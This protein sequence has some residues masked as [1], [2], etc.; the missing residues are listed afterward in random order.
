M[1]GSS[2]DLAVLDH[3]SESLE[4]SRAR[5]AKANGRARRGAHSSASASLSA[6]LDPHRQLQHVRDLAED[7]PWQL[8]LGTLPC[9]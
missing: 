3:W 7:E 8:S 4:R 6:L 9:P 2:R 1:P 5:R